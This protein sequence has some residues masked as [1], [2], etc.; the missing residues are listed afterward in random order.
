M[1]LSF[2][3]ATVEA[4]KKTCRWCCLRKTN[5]SNKEEE[6]TLEQTDKEE[7]QMN[8]YSPANDFEKAHEILNNINWDLKDSDTKHPRTISKKNFGKLFQKLRSKFGFLS[9]YQLSL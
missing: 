3:H 9:F 1:T 2:D 6:V 4:S 7:E 5:G 8:S